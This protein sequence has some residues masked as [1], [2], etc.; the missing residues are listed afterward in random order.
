MLFL[1]VA[2][3]A[4]VAIVQKVEIN[5][6]D[7]RSSCILAMVLAKVVALDMA[8]ATLMSVSGMGW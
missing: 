3:V 1:V 4:L 8:S 7:R 6:V 2:W 5:Y